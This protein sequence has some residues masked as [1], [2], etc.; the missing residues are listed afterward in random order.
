M[1][2]TY[3]HLIGSSISNLWRKALPSNPFENHAQKSYLFFTGS[4]GFCRPRSAAACVSGA[5][6]PV[7]SAAL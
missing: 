5:L 4:Y 2:Q 7:F 3:M 6:S 1:I